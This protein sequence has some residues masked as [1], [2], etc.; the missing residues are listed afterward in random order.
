MGEISLIDWI[1]R[2]TNK[3]I[4]SSF[5]VPKTP[6]RVKNEL[7]VGKFNLKPFVKRRLLK[8]LNPDGQKGKLYVLTNKA[9][10][11]LKIPPL[12]KRNQKDY[13]LL[14]GWILASPRQRYVVLKTL[15]LNSEKRTSEDI[16]LRSKNINPCLS[17]ISTKSI[18]KELRSMGLVETEMGTDRRR[19]YWITEKGR[20]LATDLYQYL[21]L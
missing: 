4:L 20:L 18:L 15:S 2:P 10:K 13:F 6:T 7:C 14:I 21:V 11:L 17:R 12:T 8:C 5:S 1:N 19:Y 3:T 16:R 9:G